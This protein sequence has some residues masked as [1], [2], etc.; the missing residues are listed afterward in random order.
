MCSED[1]STAFVSLCASHANL[2]KLKLHKM[3][4]RNQAAGYREKLGKFP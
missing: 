4:V 2:A 3:S 1:F